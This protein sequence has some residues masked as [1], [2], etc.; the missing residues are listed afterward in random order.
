MP[1]DHTPLD[2]TRL[3]PAAQRA[4]APGPGRAMA[5]RGLVP[6]PRPGE[7]AAVLYQ[8]GLD[9]DRAIAD[10]A[11]ATMEGLPEKVVLG[12]LADAEVD[13]RVVDWLA[14]RHATSPVV[15]DA[16]VMAPAVH[17]LTIVR[18]AARGDSRAV[19]LIAQ[20]EQRLLRCPDII[21]AM[22]GNPRARMSTVDRAIELAIRNNVRVQGIAAWEE[23]CRVLQAGV[24]P[25]P[26][27]DAAFAQAVAGVAAI[28]DSA[29]T[30]GDAEKAE[31]GADGELLQ[32]AAPTLDDK[33]VPI[34]KLGVPSKIRLATIGNAFARSIL[35]R[36]PI[37]MVALAAIKAPGVTDIEAARYAG[38]QQLADEVVRYI[39]GRREWTRLYGVKMHLIMNPKAPLSEVTRF[40]PHIREKDLRNIAKS[41]GVPSAVAAQ[42]RK[43]L[44]QRASG[45]KH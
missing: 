44:S 30:T 28:D 15:H 20:N 1:V 38:N 12:A 37:K 33:N 4:L 8:L 14:L 11:R 9:G 32:Q 23:L 21:A 39:A 5:A 25:T 19:D 2:P 24:A 26:A 45:G 18:L 31:L 35:I 6:L 7:L 22:Y 17:D 36:D 42:A 10:A 27:D 3:S 13:G 40:L 34:D 16:V 41:K 29:L 43:L